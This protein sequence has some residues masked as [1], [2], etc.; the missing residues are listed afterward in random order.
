MNS[1]FQNVALDQLRYSLVWEGSTTLY[2]ALDIQPDDHVLVITGAGCNVLNTLLHP[3][4]QVTAIDLN[5]EQNRLLRLKC[6][7]IQHHEYPVFRGLLGLDGA[8]AVAAAWAVVRPDLPG[9]EQEFWEA[10]FAQHPGGLLGAGRLEMY[11]N[12]FL[13]TL[14]PALQAQLR[15]LLSFGDIAKQQAYFQSVIE[16]PDSTFRPQFIEYFDAA[17]LS[18]GRDPRLFRYAQESGGALFYRRLQ[19]HLGKVLL[20]DNFF[21]RF[22][23][24]GPTGLPEDILPPCYQSG[25]YAALRAQLPRLQV[26]TGEA[27]AYLLSDAGRRITKASLSNIFEYVSEAEFERV[28]RQLGENSARRLRLVFWNLLQMQAPGSSASV[29][30]LEELSRELSAA[31]ACFYFD[32]VRVLSWA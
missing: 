13:P 29:P 28:C 31:E 3:P 32:S 15:Q 27:T 4:R 9:E 6:H 18:K 30:L 2:R 12:A 21:S 19:R 7:V 10:F 1:E 25:S 20:R 22:F 24:F 8:A 11:V 14:A 5:P 23:F 16:S 26:A 17:N